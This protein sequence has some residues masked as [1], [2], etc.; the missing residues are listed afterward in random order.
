[1]RGWKIIAAAALCGLFVMA[2]VWGNALRGQS[3]CEVVKTQVSASIAAIGRPGSPGYAYYQAHPMERQAA[4]RSSEDL[5]DK[6]P[7]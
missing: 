4:I 3:T 6:L 7:C 2:A 5:R 1:M